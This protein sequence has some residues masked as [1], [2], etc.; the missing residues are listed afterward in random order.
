MQHTARSRAESP[1][2]WQSGKKGFKTSGKERKIILKSKEI[3]ELR[4]DKLSK[5]LGVNCTKKAKVIENQSV[6]GLLEFDIVATILNDALS[7]IIRMTPNKFSN[8]FR[9]LY[10]VNYLKRKID[11]QIKSH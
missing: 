4:C 8:R 10:C 3:N 1:G 9:F 6:T 5:V 2:G 7:Y 11:H